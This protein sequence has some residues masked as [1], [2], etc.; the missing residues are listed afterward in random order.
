MSELC[1]A[2]A[3]MASLRFPQI[4]DAYIIA[5]N[6]KTLLCNLRPY[7]PV[8]TELRNCTVVQRAAQGL[9]KEII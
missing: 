3:C 4:P 9:N 6:A 1:I 8:V 7:I 2:P 5:L